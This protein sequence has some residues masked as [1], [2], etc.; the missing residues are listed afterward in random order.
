MKNR[1]YCPSRKLLVQRAKVFSPP[2]CLGSTSN[3]SVT[4]SSQLIRCALTASKP[5][6]SPR[7][8]NIIPVEHGGTHNETDLPALC[9]HCHSHKT[10]RDGIDGEN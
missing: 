5:E 7:L 3:K 10:A 8:D 1:F 4:V 2:T 9:R 6:A